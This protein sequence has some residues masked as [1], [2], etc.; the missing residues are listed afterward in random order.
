MRVLGFVALLVL[1]PACGGDE[2]GGDGG[3]GGLGGS[4]GTSSDPTPTLRFSRTTQIVG[5]GERVEVELVMEPTSAEAVTG[6]LTVE[7]TATFPDDHGF[8][9]QPF[10]FEPEQAS[11]IVDFEVVDDLEVEADEELLL[12]FTNVEGARSSGTHQIVIADEDVPSTTLTITGPQPA[13]REENAETLTFTLTLSEPAPVDVVVGLSV[14]GTTLPALDHDLDVTELTIPTG[15]TS[16]DVD[17]QVFDDVFDEDD[18]TIEVAIESAPNANIGAENG[19]VLTIEDDDPLPIV[20]VLDAKQVVSE[21]QGGYLYVRVGLSAPSGRGVRIPFSVG[22]TAEETDDYTRDEFVDV[23]PRESINGASSDFF[24]VEDDVPEVDE[25]IVITLDEPEFAVLGDFTTQ[26]ITIVDD[27][28]PGETIANP[29]IAFAYSFD[30]V[31]EGTTGVSLP[32]S[33]SGFPAS[34][35]TLPFTVDGTAP[36]PDH[37][38]ASG[39]MM[40]S[41]VERERALAFDTSG[42]D[43]VDGDRSVV[44]TLEAPSSGTLGMPSTLSVTIQDDDV[45][46]ILFEATGGDS[47][48]GSVTGLGDV[49]G[50]MIPDFAV[51]PSWTGDA[52]VYSGADFSVLF[53]VPGSRVAPAG[54]WNDDGLMDV[55]IGDPRFQNAAGDEIG[56][57]WIYD[58]NGDLLDEFEGPSVDARFA[59]TLGGGCDLDG[60]DR[61]EIVVGAPNYGEITPQLG[62]LFVYSSA[63]RELWRTFLG[64]VEGDNLGTDIAGCGGDFDGDGVQDLIGDIRQSAG[65]EA[66]P[67][68]HIYSGPTGALLF[69]H[70]R[71]G[72]YS[73]SVTSL[74]DFDGDGVDDHAFAHDDSDCTGRRCQHVE[75]RRAQTYDLLLDVPVTTAD[76]DFGTFPGSI[77]SADF[78]GDGTR[79]L[80]VVARGY[81]GLAGE[82]TGQLYV[83]SGATGEPIFVFQSPVAARALN[84]VARIGDL[85]GD[86]ADEILVGAIESTFDPG[87]GYV[88]SMNP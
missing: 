48:G 37:D 44:V 86:D 17:F 45:S 82:N 30:R 71:R 41:S 10:A 43:A 16:L 66:F 29:S 85:N 54:D 49:D 47:F 14:A 73:F 68:V 36:T 22:G 76:I 61:P 65:V 31:L 59:V 34:T 12:G 46:P 87:A 77:T 8:E 20:N 63:S 67:E 70:T 5:E 21:G 84:R 60:D 64:D 51:G 52:S 4:G 69:G 2:E 15:E 24:L 75:V 3:N 79:D 53:A 38:L 18:E 39:T 27:D 35:V 40:F 50:D 88:L 78:D 72:S 7:G 28:A 23:N 56:K 74:G 58:T 81:D 9:P 62:A 83:Y 25:T 1:L 55:L 11:L 57:V 19:F 32:V 26:T 33:L 13:S 42:N 80:V 6:E